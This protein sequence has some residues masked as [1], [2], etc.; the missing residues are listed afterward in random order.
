MSE[1]TFRTRVLRASPRLWIGLAPNRA[2]LIAFVLLAA[3]AAAA[4]KGISGTVAPITA[5]AQHPITLDPANL[6]W[7]ALRTTLRMFA[8]L[9]LLSVAGI[10]IFALLS[11]L[12]HLALRHWH[13]SAMTREL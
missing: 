9:L 6:P 2:D 8:A 1:I 4:L 12:A 10:V 11:L 5:L 3:I 13:E 7:Y